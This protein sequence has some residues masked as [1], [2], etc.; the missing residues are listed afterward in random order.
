[1]TAQFTTDW[2]YYTQQGFQI[3]FLERDRYTV[4]SNLQVDTLERLI[5]TFENT[6][7]SR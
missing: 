5:L 4:R 2:R 3:Y 7:A 1:M 6:L